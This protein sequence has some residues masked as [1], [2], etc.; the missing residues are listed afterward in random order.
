MASRIIAAAVKAVR[1]PYAGLRIAADKRIRRRRFPN[2]RYVEARRSREAALCGSIHGRR[3]SYR[4]LGRY[5]IHGR[6]G[7]FEGCPPSRR[8][9]VRAKCWQELQREMI[10]RQ[11]PRGVCRACNADRYDR[12]RPTTSLTAWRSEP[13]LEPCRTNPPVTQTLHRTS[14]FRTRKRCLPSV[15][16]SLEA[17]GFVSFGTTGKA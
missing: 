1:H 3:S 4:R 12:A 10:A 8:N 5:R 2:G 16:R 6:P 17:L 9:G 14:W 11:P 13:T 7:V 15:K